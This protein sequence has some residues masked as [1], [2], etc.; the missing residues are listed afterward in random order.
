MRLWGQRRGPTVEVLEA[1]TE[2]DAV[3]EGA[4]AGETALRESV[5]A[6]HESATTQDFYEEEIQ[7]A[8]W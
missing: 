8:D 6:L 5:A 3:P 1:D 7:F 4:E 2:S